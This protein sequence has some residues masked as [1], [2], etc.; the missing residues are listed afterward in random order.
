MVVVL[1][2]PSGP[3]RPKTSPCPTTRS[4]PSTAETAPYLLTRPVAWIAASF[5]ALPF[6]TDVDLGVR[7]HAG[8]QQALGIFQLDL[9]GK[10]ELG[11]LLFC[12][13]R[14]GGK[15]RLV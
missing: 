2:A 13:H 6:R 4:R 7:R 1:P 10:N 14:L 15:L 5:T 9:H 12:L 11:A 8:F 3:I